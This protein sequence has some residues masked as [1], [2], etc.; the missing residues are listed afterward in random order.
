MFLKDVAR[1]S[2]EYPRAPT[3]DW[4]PKG[5]GAHLIY[6]MPNTEIKPTACSKPGF[7]VDQVGYGCQISI[8]VETD[9]KQ[10]V[11]GVSCTVVDG[12]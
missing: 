5:K 11:L 7:K 6:A 3:S 8:V 12:S 10:G 4:G 1:N 9:A 2:Q